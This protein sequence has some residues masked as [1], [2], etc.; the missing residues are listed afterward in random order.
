MSPRYRAKEEA[1]KHHR[2]VKDDDDDDVAKSIEIMVW[3]KKRAVLF[4]R[5]DDDKNDTNEIK[6][7]VL[8]SLLVLYVCYWPGLEDCSSGPD[9]VSR[10]LSR[11]GFVMRRRKKEKKIRQEGPRATARRPFV[12]S[13]VVT[14]Y[15]VR[16][17]RRVVVFEILYELYIFLASHL[18]CRQLHR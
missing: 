6:K 12:N 9:I 18:S 7:Q 10:S 4:V 17:I 1:L 5:D 16:R 15:Y 13:R 2:A 14:L 3:K 8:R 11:G